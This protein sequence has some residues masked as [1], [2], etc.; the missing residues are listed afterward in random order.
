MNRSADTVKAEKSE[1]QEKFI[2]YQSELDSLIKNERSLR[3]KYV[4]VYIHICMYMHIIIFTPHDHITPHAF[5]SPFAQKSGQN[6]VNK[7]D[8]PN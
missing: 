5:I 8:L 4:Q 1:I 3:E 7:S 2:M 6:P